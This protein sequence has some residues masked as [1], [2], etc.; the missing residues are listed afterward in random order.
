MGKGVQKTLFREIAKKYGV[1]ESTVQNA[2][3]G[4]TWKCVDYYP[5]PT[6]GEQQ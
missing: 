1:S 4:R 2:A 5:E 6:K 3:S